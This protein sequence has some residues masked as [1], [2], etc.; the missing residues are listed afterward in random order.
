MSQQTTQKVVQRIP[1]P[2]AVSLTVI[3]A[4]PFALYLGKFNLPLWVAFIVWA[5]YFALGATVETW[6][7]IIPSIPAGA[8][9]GALWMVTATFVN[10]LIGGD[11]IWGLIVGTLIWI[12]ALLYII[13]RVP[14]F[15]NGTLAVFNGLAL[16]LGV[17]FTGSVPSV[18]AMG[19]PYWVIFLA[20]IWTILVAYFGWFLGWLNITI[21]FPKVVEE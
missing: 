7:L 6:K 3:V 15:S 13:P 18:G 12:T 20:L 1:L 5:E 10:N 19:N 4:L 11:L 21:T 2:W 9:T 16:Y 14:A 8:L 17:Y